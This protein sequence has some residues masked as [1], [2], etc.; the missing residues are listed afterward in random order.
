[1]S[2]IRSTVGVFPPPMFLFCRITHSLGGKVQVKSLMDAIRFFA[3]LGDIDESRIALAGHSYGGFL[4]L[5]ALSMDE[6]ICDKMGRFEDM[7]FVLFVP[8]IGICNHA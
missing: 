6:V 3:N 2:L 4:T 5:R 7:Y 8:K 1:M